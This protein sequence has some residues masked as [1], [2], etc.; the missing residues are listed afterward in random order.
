MQD[1]CPDWFL[2]CCLTKMLF[3]F[4]KRQK[5]KKTPTQPLRETHIQSCHQVHE[6]SVLTP[7]AHFMIECLWQMSVCLVL[8]FYW[9]WSI[10]RS[11]PP[12]STHPPST[13]ISAV[14]MGTGW[15]TLEKINWNDLLLSGLKA[16]NM[17]YRTISKAKNR[18]VNNVSLPHFV[19]SYIFD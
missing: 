6:I 15:K 14:T 3:F 18:M 13:F 8:S 19:P 11:P 4:F 10:V 1:F 12:P 7:R 2:L 16:I 5:T 17:W 9:L